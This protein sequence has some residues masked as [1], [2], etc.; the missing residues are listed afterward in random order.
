[1]EKQVTGKIN[2]NVKILSVNEKPAAI[3]VTLPEKADGGSDDR[4]YERLFLERFTE[5][6]KYGRFHIEVRTGVLV[7]DSSAD[8]GCVWG[9][10]IPQATE[11]KLRR[12]FPEGKAY[13]S[14][15]H[16]LKPFEDGF[17]FVGGKGVDR[18]L[19]VLEP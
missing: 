15:L 13:P 14:Q 9:V 10:N 2:V 18:L 7:F 8:D 17:I 1:M 11:D 4:Y 19:K 6:F 5:G 12:I 16:L 3:K